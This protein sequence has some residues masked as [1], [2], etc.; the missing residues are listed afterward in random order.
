MSIRRPRYRGI[1]HLPNLLV[2]VQPRGASGHE[3]P[4]GNRGCAK[5]LGP[6]EFVRLR[7]ELDRV[8]QSLWASQ[9]SAATRERAKRASKISKST[10]CCE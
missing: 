1:I 9:L 3:I 5:H 6:A 2:D 4:G 10:G 7:K 8:E